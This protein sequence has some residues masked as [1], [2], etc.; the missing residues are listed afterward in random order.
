[1]SLTNRLGRKVKWNVR[2]CAR[3]EHGRGVSTYLARYVKGGPFN[4]AQIARADHSKVI[5]RYTPHAR[6]TGCKR[7]AVL[8]LSPERFLARV[9]G[10]A[11]EPHR[12]TVRYYGLYAHAC[13]EHLNAARKLHG[14]AP[15]AAPAPMPWQSYLARF[16]RALPSAHCPRCHAPLVRGAL[17]PARRAPP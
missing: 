5:F 16:P 15:A 3:Y 11:P 7:T 1:M 10:H 17:I 14:Q 12:H 4:N 8:A 2:V 13:A 9:L 6:Q